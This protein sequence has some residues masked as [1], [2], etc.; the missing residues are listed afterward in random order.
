MV[1]ND[2]GSTRLA[3]LVL[4]ED[5]HDLEDKI[6]GPVRRLWQTVLRHRI[7]YGESDPRRR[8]MGSTPLASPETVPILGRSDYL[9]G[10]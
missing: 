2:L 1:T 4:V 9:P 8:R 7:Q 5:G 6:V 10:P 3:R